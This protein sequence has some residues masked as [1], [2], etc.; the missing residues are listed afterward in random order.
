[1]RKEQEIL[2]ND[3][4]Y[5]IKQLPAKKG[6]RLITTILKMSESLFAN[7]NKKN[8][9][10]S[11]IGKIVEGVFSKIDEDRTI[12]VI[13]ETITESVVV[14]K[15]FDVNLDFAGNYDSLF[16]LFYEILKLNFESSLLKLK[17]KVG[18]IISDMKSKSDQKEST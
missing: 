13:M 18:G 5:R 17:K 11:D 6:L 4:E 8:A 7:V 1:M 14:P 12:D 16:E 9:L 2:I 10:D 15:D 3:K